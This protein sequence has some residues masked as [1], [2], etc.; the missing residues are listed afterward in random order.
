MPEF[1]YEAANAEGRMMKGQISAGSL[2]EAQRSLRAQGLAPVEIGLTTVKAKP[3]RPPKKKSNRQDQILVMGE[4][5]VLLD[6]GVALAEAVKSLGHS[7]LP[8]DLSQ[9]FDQ[10]ERGLRQG[11][12]FSVALK[13]HLPMLP[14]YVHQLV[15]AGEMTGQLAEALR[16]GAAQMDYDYRVLQ[17]IRNALVY[18]SVLVGAGVTA[19]LF[20][21]IVVVPRF[22][23][24]FQSARVEIPLLSKI[25]LTIGLF[26]RDHL[27]ELGLGFG[28]FVVVV[29]MLSRRPAVRAAAM[30]VAPKLPLFG[31]WLDETE[32]GRWAAMLSILLRNKIPLIQALELSRTG[33]R[34]PS[35]RDRMSQVEK[36][37]RGGRSLADALS[38]HTDMM[39][40]GLNLV[41]IG[42]RAGNLPDMLKSLASLNERSA[43]D[44]MKR[45][46]L[47]I[48]PLAII[49]IGAVIGLIVTAIM[50]AVTSISNIQ[51]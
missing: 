31:G 13:A 15:A 17:E 6:A 9:A 2:R 11:Q 37:V 22:A 39:P 10:I 49:I 16:D 8:L 38:A 24:M 36:A 1:S 12:R 20:I 30:E 45:F 42:E 48:E 51:I 23:A 19:V 14:T 44:R 26:T 28:L 21:F 32:V 46:L 25:V 27:L 3:K 4:L 33:L 47:V 5:A 29:L 34:I 50:L 43:K 40:I 18:P 41:R 35:V 7:D